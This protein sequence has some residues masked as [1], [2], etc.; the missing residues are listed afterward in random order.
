M[1][2]AMASTP[3]GTDPRKG[4]LRRAVEYFGLLEATGD[5]ARKP[6]T[7]PRRPPAPGGTRAGVKALAYFGLAEDLDDSHP[8]GPR[9][10]RR[11]LDELLERVEALEDEVAALRRSQRGTSPG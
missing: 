11:D 6:S 3:F 5:T 4:R 1:L 2:A 7:A 10:L 9:V 8:R